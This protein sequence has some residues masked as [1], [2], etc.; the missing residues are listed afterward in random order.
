M[1]MSR[2]GLNLPDT[3]WWYVITEKDMADTCATC[4]LITWPWASSM[5]MMSKDSVK[6]WFLWFYR[7]IIAKTKP[8]LSKLMKMEAIVCRRWYHGRSWWHGRR[9]WQRSCPIVQR[10]LISLA[11]NTVKLYRSY[12]DARLAGS[13]SPSRAEVSTLPTLWFSAD[14]MLSMKPPT[15]SI[16]SKLWSKWSKLL[17]LRTIPRLSLWPIDQDVTGENREYSAVANAAVSPLKNSRRCHRL[18]NCFW[19]YCC[20]NFCRTSTSNHLLWLRMLRGQPLALNY[21]NASFER[22]FSENYGIDLVQELTLLATS[23]NQARR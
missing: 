6:S 19:C 4:D 12:S 20:L 2:K 11:V 18:W 10:K 7:Q 23:I 13:P 9:S 22:P 1:I 21:A 3:D 14:A 5:L 15:V 17:H 16:Q 8:K